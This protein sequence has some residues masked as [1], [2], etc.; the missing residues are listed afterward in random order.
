MSRLMLCYIAICDPSLAIV[1]HCICSAVVAEITN[2]VFQQNNAR[3]H[4]PRRNLKSLTG[5]NML[6]RPEN[7][8]SLNPIEH[9]W[10]LL[11][12]DMNG[13]PIVHNPG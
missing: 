13:L 12:R 8:P 5:A 3:Q 6:H 11:G 2:T 4:V 1:Q 9:L 7:S 10:D